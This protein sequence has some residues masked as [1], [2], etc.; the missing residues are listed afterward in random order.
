[1]TSTHDSGIQKADYGPVVL[2]YADRPMKLGLGG[3]LPMMSVEP[4]ANNEQAI[5]RAC[6][7]VQ[8]DHFHNPLIT[9]PDSTL[10]IFRARELLDE[11]ARRL[12][13]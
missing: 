8:T 12:A 2:S 6:V 13:I 5:Q 1:M 4:F 3:G 9:T 7:L 10:A 11:C